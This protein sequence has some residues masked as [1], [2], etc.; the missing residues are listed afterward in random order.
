MVSMRA[1]QACPSFL[2]PTHSPEIQ[3][4]KESET[5]QINWMEQKI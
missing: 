3:T 1:G 2:W 5:D 4:G